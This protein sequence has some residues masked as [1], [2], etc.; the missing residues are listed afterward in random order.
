MVAFLAL[1]IETDMFM[2]ERSKVVAE[3]IVSFKNGFGI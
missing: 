1:R 3:L 2:N